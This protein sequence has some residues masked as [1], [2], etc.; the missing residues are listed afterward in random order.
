[1]FGWGGFSIESL[2][3]GF[4][5]LRSTEAFSVAAGTGQASDGND[6]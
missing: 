4:V 3:C 6:N 5:M 2:H 1:V